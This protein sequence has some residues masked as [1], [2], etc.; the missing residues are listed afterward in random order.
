MHHL[1]KTLRK[2]RDMRP[3]VGSALIAVSL[4]M[5]LG[6]FSADLS[7][8]VAVAQVTPDVAAAGLSGAAEIAGGAVEATAEAAGSVFEVIAEIV[9]SLF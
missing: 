1:L 2:G 5:L 4:F 7:A 9:A 6:F 8:S 3:W